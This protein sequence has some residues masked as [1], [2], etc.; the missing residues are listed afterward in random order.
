MVRV[1][2][3]LLVAAASSLLLLLLLVAPS[4]AELTRVEHPPKTEGS[5]AIL[6]VGDWG[7]RG[8]FNQ[9]LVAQQVSAENKHNLKYRSTSAFVTLTKFL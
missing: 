1:T 5:L 4:A 3:L 7:R 9:T 2:P 6:A 8:Q